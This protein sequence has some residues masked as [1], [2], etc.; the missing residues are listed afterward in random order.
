MNSLRVAHK[1]K[2][3]R[4][5][6]QRAFSLAGG[7]W[8]TA[9]RFDRAMQHYTGVLCWLG[10]GTIL[11]F[12]TVV[13]ARHPRLT[14]GY[15]KRGLELATKGHRRMD[16]QELTL[17]DQVHHLVLAQLVFRGVG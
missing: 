8:L 1:G 13:L 10:C 6:A 15:H 7:Y 11:P 9:D 17:E 4:Q 12:V 16:Y 14:Q 5:M 3:L 2:G